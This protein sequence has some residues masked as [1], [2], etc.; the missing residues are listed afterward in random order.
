MQ[1]LEG[2]GKKKIR[3]RDLINIKLASGRREHLS[4]SEE[5]IAESSLKDEK[6]ES[7]ATTTTTYTKQDN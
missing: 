4:S 7:A 1:Q 3:M 6:H 2:G 5:V